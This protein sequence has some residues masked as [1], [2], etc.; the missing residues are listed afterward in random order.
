[1][2]LD[3]CK[4]PRASLCSFN[5]TLFSASTLFNIVAIVNQYKFIFVV[6]MVSV[7]IVIDFITFVREDTAEVVFSSVAITVVNGKGML[8][9]I[10]V[11]TLVQFYVIQL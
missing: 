2:P 7:G 9:P 4:S 11:K 1:M 6:V 3:G 10:Q 5:N 8:V